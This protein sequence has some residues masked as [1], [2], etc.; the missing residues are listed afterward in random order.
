MHA[1]TV[2]ETKVVVVAEGDSPS[3]IANARGHLF[4]HFIARLSARFGFTEPRRENLNVTSNGIELDIV[5]THVSN[6][7]TVL[8]ECKAYSSPVP[9]KELVAFYGKVHARRLAEPE[10]EG[11]MFV[12]PGLT[13]EGAEQARTIQAR[14][15]LFRYFDAD[16]VAD[17]ARQLHLIEPLPVP[18]RDRMLVDPALVVTEH[19]IFS[20]RVVLDIDTRQG[21]EVVVWGPVPVPEPVVTLVAAD[22]YARGL[23]IVA[24]WGT[25][26]VPPAGVEADLP[27]LVEVRGGES[28]LDHRL[29]AAAE[30]F[31]GRERLISEI[32][33][34]VGAVSSVVIHAK[35]GWGKSSV[36]LRLKDE[37]ERRGG[38]ATVLDTRAVSH[39]GYAAAA[40]RQFVDQAATA[41]LVTLGGEQSWDG[42]ASAVRSVGDATWNTSGRPLLL[43][44]DQFESVF[45]DELAARDFR[46]LLLA[47]SGAGIPLT[48]GFAWRTDLADWSTDIAH[49]VR[50]QILAASAVFTLQTWTED[51]IDGFLTSPHAG[52]SAGTA[53]R[54]RTYGQGL[55]WLLKKL[56][57]H[58]TGRSTKV[59]AHQQLDVAALFEQD[60]AGLRPMERRAL[61]KIASAAPVPADEAADLAPAVVIDS[62]IAAR[63][64]VDVGGRLDTYWDL[65]R[66]Y[67]ISGQ[68]PEEVSSVVRHLRRGWTPSGWQR[69][70][71]YEAMFVEIAVATATVLDLDGS[72][73]ELFDQIGI[74][75]AET[76]PKGSQ[77]G[78]SWGISDDADMETNLLKIRSRE[79]LRTALAA[80]GLR[81]PTTVGELAETLATIGV[82]HHQ[83]ENGVERWR[84]EDDLPEV[85]QVLTLPDEFVQDE[86]RVA[87]LTRILPATDQ[88]FQHL[89]DRGRPEVLT[90]SVQ[91]LADEATMD[92]S[93][94]RVALDGMIRY[95]EARV[96]RFSVD[97]APAD[98]EHLAGHARITLLLGWGPKDDHE[99]EIDLRS[100]R[101]SG[102]PWQVYQRVA[103][104]FSQVGEDKEG[105]ITTLGALPFAARFS[106]GDSSFYSLAQAAV[107]GRT[108]VL[109]AAQAFQELADRGLLIWK[110]EIQEVWFGEPELPERPSPIGDTA[111]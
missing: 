63:L 20:A 39:H 15:S 16:R 17:I 65:F 26:G 93:V 23:P 105:L 106:G 95:R 5:L 27:V 36:A 100:L 49:P 25:S 71:P 61:E 58:I 72:L 14:D 108:S 51:E 80:R 45:G 87:L 89:R 101:W 53:A 90:T 44:F 9:A 52:L 48:L 43:F 50:H 85:A 40:L 42:V 66:E 19:G 1:M 110:H 6:G 86:Q 67:L 4:E 32:V 75:R 29:P 98:L 10:T 83:T 21:V 62:L 33:E 70:L 18:L 28:G 103:E 55:P 2:Q 38:C 78:L 73:D 41:G 92:T 88:L 64:L 91:R 84:C 8:V 109:A 68:L 69:L 30:F 60:L 99:E 94:V 37:I 56:A 22:R 3:E 81:L 47:M 54:L 96:Q 57:E 82:Y 102:P 12:L 34:Q 76:L 97:V 13:S 104:Q 77:T 107:E 74:S 35:S 24:Y 111:P 79:S 7:R 11:L 59:L 31:V 46:D